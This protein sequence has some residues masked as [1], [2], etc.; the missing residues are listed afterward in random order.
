MQTLWYRAPEVML[1][2]KQYTFA[3]DIWAVGCIFAELFLKR[4]LFLGGEYEIEQIYKVFEVM[5]TPLK[6]EWPTI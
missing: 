2:M 5:G 4:P 3:I 6:E 1:G